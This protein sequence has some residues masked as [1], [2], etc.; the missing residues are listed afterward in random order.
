[1]ETA[2]VKNWAAGLDRQ[3]RNGSGGEDYRLTRSKTKDPRGHLLQHGTD[4][5]EN[6]VG[7]VGGVDPPVQDGGEP[8]VKIPPCCIRRLTPDPVKPAGNRARRAV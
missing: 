1:M 3:T 7:L 8:S 5:G 2:P 4:A 6:C